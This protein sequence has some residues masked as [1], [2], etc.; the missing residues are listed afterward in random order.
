MGTCGS[1]YTNGTDGSLFCHQGQRCN[2][3]TDRV[4]MMDSHQPLA[5]KKN[6]RTKKTWTK[7]QKKRAEAQRKELQAPRTDARPEREVTPAEPR[8]AKKAEK[9]LLSTRCQ[10]ALH[11]ARC[12]DPAWFD[13]KPLHQCTRKMSQ[14]HSPKCATT[15]GK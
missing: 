1:G 10:L 11:A 8:S 12:L 13:C 3:S 2:R 9:R 15:S 14:S 7:A 5:M 6:R 4:S